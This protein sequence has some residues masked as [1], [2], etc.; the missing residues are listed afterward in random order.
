MEKALFYL[1]SFLLSLTTGIGGLGSGETV[2]PGKVYLEPQKSEQFTSPSITELNDEK[3]KQLIGRA[4]GRAKPLMLFLWY[5]DCQPCRER[6]PIVERIY[7]EYA[8]RGLEVALVSVG[9][10]D[11]RVKL[12]RYILDQRLKIPA[13]LL[14]DLTDELGEDVFQTD[15]EIIVPMVLIYNRK[16]RLIASRTR[17]EGKHYRDIQTVVEKVLRSN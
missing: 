3:I 5:T 4:G 2:V 14:D 7:H 6:L 11:N 13:Y 1:L 8:G 10:M 15:E 9:P 16:G 17:L 12:S